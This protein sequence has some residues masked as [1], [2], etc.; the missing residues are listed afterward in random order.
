MNPSTAT[1]LSRARRL[2]DS[3]RFPEAIHAYSDLVGADPTCADAW[4]EL[5]W[6]LRRSGDPERALSAYGRALAAGIPAPEQTLLNRAVI[7][8]ADL[9]QPEAAEAELRHALRQHPDY[10]PALLNL[11]KL[12]E[13]SGDQRTAAELYERLSRTATHRELALEGLVR[14]VQIDLPREAQAGR[15]ARL[16][17]CAESPEFPRELRAR[18]WFALG[19]CAEAVGSFDTAFEAFSAGN[20]LA[21]ASMPPYRP[22]AL[23]RHVDALIANTPPADTAAGKDHAQLFI[24]GMFRSGSTLLEQVLNAHPKVVAGGELAFFPRMATGPLA[25]FVSGSEMP[26]EIANQTRRAYRSVLERL[27]QSSGKD[28]NN[29]HWL[30][31]KRPDNI[32]MLGLLRRLF[33]AAR[34]IITRRNPLDTGLSVFQQHLDLAQA[35]YSSSLEGIAHYI[36]QIERITAHARSAWADSV[37]VFDYDAFVR[38]P[39]AELAPLLTWLGLEWEPACLRFHEQRNLVATASHAQVR[40]PLYREAS[41]RWKHYQAHLAPLSQRLEQLGLLAGEQ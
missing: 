29:I 6:V 19:R 4:Y 17:H 1:L 24:C 14:L 26:E 9:A 20:R 3:G 31:D 37:Y 34:I 18:A 30:T 10:G 27:A 38:S 36:A 7:L 28:T 32:L 21:A 8:S 40:R 15:L 41:G 25:P 2:V 11:G 33:P 12:K 5:G 35:P 22:E 16:R 39:E 13:D 23:E